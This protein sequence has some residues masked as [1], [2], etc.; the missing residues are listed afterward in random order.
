MVVG[1]QSQVV[2]ILLL[3]NYCFFLSIIYHIQGQNLEI[4]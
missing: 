1:T 4:K 3:Y 2:R